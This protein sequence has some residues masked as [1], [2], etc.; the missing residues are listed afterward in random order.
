M[1]TREDALQRMER[2]GE[3]DPGCLGCRERYDY[4]G[5][6]WEVFMP[7]HK[8]SP[9]CESGRRPHCTCDTCF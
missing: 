9:R 5:M 2:A 4:P 7:N 3:L 1:E 6:P 8:A